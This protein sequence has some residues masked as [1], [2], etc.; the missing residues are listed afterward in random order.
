MAGVL[1]KRQVL[2]RI[3]AAA[4]ANKAKLK[5]SLDNIQEE[6]NEAPSAM[7][8]HSDTSRFQTGVLKSALEDECN[9]AA[10]FLLAVKKVDVK[11]MP[12]SIQVG[13]IAEI[14]EGGRSFLAIILPLP[15]PSERIK[16]RGQEIKIVTVSSPIGEA[17]IGKRVGDT[18]TVRILE[19]VR[20][21]KVVRVI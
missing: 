7:Q 8:S 20:V 13:T 21:L 18:V 19:K 4:E 3:I 14:K 17:L 2:A 15:G 11:V 6:I 1:H 16:F 10:K 12:A 5:K 9:E